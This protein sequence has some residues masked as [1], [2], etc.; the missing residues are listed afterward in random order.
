MQ[1]KYNSFMEILA[2]FVSRN[3]WELH[4]GEPVKTAASIVKWE[5][6]KLILDGSGSLANGVFLR[7]DREFGSD[8]T[9]EEMVR[10]LRCDEE[11]IFKMIDVEED[12]S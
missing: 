5:K 3:I 4:A 9:I 6:R 7:F 12:K 1:P 10:E 2:P 11:A 8:T